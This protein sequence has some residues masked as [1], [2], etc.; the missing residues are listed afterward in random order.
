MFKHI[1]TKFSCLDALLLEAEIFKATSRV[2]DLLDICLLREI[3]QIFKLLFCNL[4][5]PN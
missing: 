3:L 2:S 4:V 1:F 5:G